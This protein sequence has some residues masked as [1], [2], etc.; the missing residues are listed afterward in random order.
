MRPEFK[1]IVDTVG[2]T[3]KPGKDMTISITDGDSDE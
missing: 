2:E 3:G 1:T